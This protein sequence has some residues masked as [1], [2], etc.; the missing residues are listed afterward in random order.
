MIGPES[1]QPVLKTIDKN[2]C[3]LVLHTNTGT[4]TELSNNI[5]TY[6]KWSN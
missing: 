6:S 3:A 1:L 4:N 5:Y 2:T